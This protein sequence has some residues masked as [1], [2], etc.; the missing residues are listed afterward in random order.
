VKFNEVIPD[1]HCL[2][3]THINFYYHLVR[4]DSLGSSQI[5]ATTAFHETTLL[6]DE[7]FALSTPSSVFPE[8]FV[9]YSVFNKSMNNILSVKIFANFRAKT[10][11]LREDPGS[12]MCRSAV[13]S[14]SLLNLLVF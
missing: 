13:G 9:E 2:I 14:H 3:V 7:S 10:R 8:P 1:P 5:D 12:P 11:F 4:D 6:M